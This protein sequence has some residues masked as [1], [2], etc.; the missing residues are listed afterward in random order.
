MVWYDG[1]GHGCGGI[2]IGTAGL[3][4][5]AGLWRRK[6][7][8]TGARDKRGAERPASCQVPKFP[9]PGR[10]IELII[11]DESELQLMPEWPKEAP[12]LAANPG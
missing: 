1:H 10:G 4:K 11:N 2:G 12:Q 3:E 6:S 8:L 7:G 9:R 5:T